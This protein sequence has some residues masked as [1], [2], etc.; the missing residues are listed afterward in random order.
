MAKWGEGDPRWHVEERPDATNVNNWHWTE[1]NANAWSKKK[2]ESLLL[3]CIIEDPKLGN[4]C[5]EKIEKCEGE[6]IVCNR[7]AKLIFF[8]EWELSLK[9]KE[10]GFPWTEG[11]V[12]IPNFSE[13]HDDINGVDLIIQV[14]EGQEH[15]GCESL[16]EMMRKG[17]GAKVIREKLKEYVE[18]LRIEYSRNVILPTNASSSEK[19]AVVID[20]NAVNAD[21]MKPLGPLMGYTK[22]DVNKR[23]EDVNSLKILFPEKHPRLRI[24]SS[25]MDKVTFCFIDSVL[26]E[27]I[28]H[29][30]IGDDYPD[31]PPVWISESKIERIGHALELMSEKY[32]KA[33]AKMSEKQKYHFVRNNLLLRQVKAILK[34]LCFMFSLPEPEESL[35]INHNNWQSLSSGSGAST[36]DGM[37]RGKN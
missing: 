21:K 18:A 2:L 33:L 31:T 22:L 27:H 14:T 17:T 36:I 5:L 37:N 3:N 30:F 19:Q 13:E 12:D 16:K 29:A 11:I 32:K 10:Q 9:W 35:V 15:S 8:Y 20:S 1:K 6:A 7:K 23:K 34:G 26:E 28:I 25:S 4:V 24:R